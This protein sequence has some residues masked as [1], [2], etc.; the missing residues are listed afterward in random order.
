[1]SSA[2]ASPS[3]NPINYVSPQPLQQAQSAVNV[4]AALSGPQLAQQANQT[5]AAGP[6]W[7][8]L[9]NYNGT[10]NPSAPGGQGG[11]FDQN[12]INQFQNWYQQN[13]VNPQVSQ[14]LAQ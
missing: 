5:M 12:L 4:P 10:A 7:L 2:P 13:Q 11:P 8:N 14:I 9:N 3:F 1:M 6:S